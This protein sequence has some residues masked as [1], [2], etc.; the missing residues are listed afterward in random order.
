MFPESLVVELAIRSEI[1]LSFV[2]GIPMVLS[3][4]VGGSK[5]SFLFALDIHCFLPI[6]AS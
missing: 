6:A 4:Q 5:Y 1:K 3:V 2:H